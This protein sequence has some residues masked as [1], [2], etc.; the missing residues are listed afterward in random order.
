EATALPL[1]VGGLEQLAVE[2]EAVRL[3]LVA[4]AAE[5]GLEEG[6]GSRHAVVGQRLARCRAR[7]RAVAPR[8]SEALMAPDVT[9]RARHAAAGERHVVVG[10]FSKL[11]A[12][13]DEGP[14]L[15]ERGVTG[16]TRVRRR[17]VALPHLDELAGNAGPARH[18]VQALAPVGELRRMTGPARLRLERGFERREPR[19]WR[20]L[21]RQRLSP[22]PLDEIPNEVRAAGRRG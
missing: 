22:V 11:A 20:A 8:R 9:G 1:V 6:G 2:R 10:I 18:R 12:D 3:E 19:G 5:L 14:L 16:Q 13:G 17:R 21:R 7:H 4:A 15:G